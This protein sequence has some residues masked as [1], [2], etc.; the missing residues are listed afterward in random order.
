M[1][2]N[3]PEVRFADI[4]VLTIHLDITNQRV[5]SIE[6]DSAHTD[7]MLRAVP[8]WACLVSLLAA[9]A[10]NASPAFLERDV[11]GTGTGT[12]YCVRSTLERG[13]YF[14]ASRIGSS[15]QVGCLGS[16]A[17][18]GKCGWFT[19]EFCSQLKAGEPPAI[20]RV[21]AFT[22]PTSGG[23]GWCGEALAALAAQG[24]GSQ[25][26]PPSRSG[27]IIRYCT[28]SSSD[29]GHFMAR[30]SSIA[31]GSG[32]YL[33]GCAGG[34]LESDGKCSWF[35]DSSCTRLTPDSVALKTDIMGH[36]CT[37]DGTAPG[38]CRDAGNVMAN[39][40]EVETE[41]A[42]SPSTTSSTTSSTT[43]TSS[44]P[45]SVDTSTRKGEETAPLVPAWG[46]A[47]IGVVCG[48]AFL[49]ALYGFWKGCLVN[50]FAKKDKAA[51]QYPAEVEE[52]PK[53]Q[54]TVLL[55]CQLHDNTSNYRCTDTARF[56]YKIGPAS[57]P[58]CGRRCHSCGIG[59]DSYG[60]DFPRGFC[61]NHVE[62]ADEFWF[63]YTQQGVNIP[64]F[65]VP[66]DSPVDALP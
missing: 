41:Q 9:T 46:W 66:E 56:A 6:I 59:V 58:F 57:I 30:S 12:A 33:Y 32:G 14:V 40:L 35:L 42:S 48:L 2:S 64:N 62:N 43:T 29:N 17:G 31:D 28:K 27:T 60:G 61:Q 52:D 47:L 11:I 25:T 49:V 13:F 5:L 38:W 4:S 16:D 1:T 26:Y 19:D 53:L 44:P 54:K 8:L 65:C 45:T 20:P 10:V 37:K 23:P 3:V 55:I 50:H 36:Y 7:A 24:S 21:I 51:E 34:G 15:T 18:S 39:N 63:V 22:C